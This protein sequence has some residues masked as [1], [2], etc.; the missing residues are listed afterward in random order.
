MQP[1]Y[2]EYHRLHQQVIENESLPWKVRPGQSQKAEVQEH[3]G[4]GG[5][6]FQ[7]CK[8]FIEQ[9]FAE[10]RPFFESQDL[11]QIWTLT[12]TR[13]SIL[14][15]ISDYAQVYD[16][17]VRL[18]TKQSFRTYAT[19]FTRASWRLNEPDQ[20]AYFVVRIRYGSRPQRSQFTVEFDW[21]Q[22]MQKLRQRASSSA[23]CARSEK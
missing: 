19:S 13:S 3:E 17:T 4:G 16:Q 7:R 18:R 9:P 23:S 14:M 5:K 2:A 1:Q 10:V 20:N 22:R 11:E 12:E 6:V 15:K 21:V 8:L